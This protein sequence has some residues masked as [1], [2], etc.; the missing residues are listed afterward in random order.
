MI[1]NPH[2]L[3]NSLADFA[4]LFAKVPQATL[5]LDVAHAAY[6][7]NETEP[8][9]VMNEH[10]KKI[11]HVLISDNDRFDADHLFLGARSNQPRPVFLLLSEPRMPLS[12]GRFSRPSEQGTSTSDTGG[13]RAFN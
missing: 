3:F 7:V 8:G 5:L 13:A 12:F 4:T 11:R 6:L 9:A 1:E 2:P 10:R